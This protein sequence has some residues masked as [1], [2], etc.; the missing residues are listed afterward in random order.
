MSK[1]GVSPD[2]DNIAKIVN[3]PTP[4]NVCN[5]QGILSIG[6]HYHRFVKELIQKAQPLLEL[7]KK[8][9]PFRWTPECQAAFDEI[10][11]DLIGPDIM[12]FP[13]DD[14]L[15]SLD[16]DVADDS[17]LCTKAETVKCREGKCIWQP[18]IRQV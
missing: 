10:K 13:I 18:N 6:N 8:N 15:Y 12:A 3:W 14:D 7:T 2:P 5:V 1:D 17:R 4:K 9:K 16:C 11:Q